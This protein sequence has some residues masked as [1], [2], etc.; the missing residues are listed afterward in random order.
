MFQPSRRSATSPASRS[1]M[2]CCEMC[3]WRKPKVASMWQT[4]CS[5]SRSA[6]SIAMRGGCISALKYWVWDWYLFMACLPGINIRSFEYYSSPIMRVCQAS[7]V[8]SRPGKAEQ[9]PA[10][11]G[12]SSV[13]RSNIKTYRL[14]DG[15]LRKCLSTV[16]AVVPI[17]LDR[18]T[19]IRTGARW[20]G[21]S[22]GATHRPHQPD[23]SCH[24]QYDQAKRDQPHEDHADPAEWA[25]PP[26]A[27]HAWPHHA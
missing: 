23:N 1:T 4:H 18:A 2:R 7:F 13:E 25:K 15:L 16:R 9:R 22:P 3:A 26:S 27:H 14:K 17:G 21:R 6:S 10:P 12:S 24:H 20:R 8:T 11:S 19:A 5:P